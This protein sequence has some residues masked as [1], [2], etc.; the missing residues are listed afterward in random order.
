MERYKLTIELI[1]ECEDESEAETQIKAIIKEG[2][3]AVDDCSP[4]DGFE[5]INIE[6]AEL[7]Y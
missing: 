1:I 4:I 3:L 5:I 2:T 6:P 7:P